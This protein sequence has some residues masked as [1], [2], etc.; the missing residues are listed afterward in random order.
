MK[1]AVCTIDTGV[2]LIQ[3][4]QQN[5][6]LSFLEKLNEDITTLISDFKTGKKNIPVTNAPV[7]PSFKIDYLN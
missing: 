2:L 6:I 5:D 3:N 7:I 4:V 1:Q